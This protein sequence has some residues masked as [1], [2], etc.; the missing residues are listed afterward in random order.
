MNFVCAAHVAIYDIGEVGIC[1]H[2]TTDDQFCYFMRGTKVR[3][4]HTSRRDAFRSINELPLLRIFPEGKITT[5]DGLRADFSDG[6]GLVRASNT[7]PS[8]VL[9]FE[10][11]N[12]EELEKIKK[13]MHDRLDKLIA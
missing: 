11:T 1:M 2:G 4:M 7:T 13:A 5:I 10:A 12:Q 8:L 6:W 3:K 9:R